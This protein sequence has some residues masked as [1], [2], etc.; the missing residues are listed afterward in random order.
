[1]SLLPW[2]SLSCS[3][4]CSLSWESW[5]VSP[6]LALPIPPNSVVTPV[7]HLHVAIIPRIQV[8]SSHMIQYTLP[9]QKLWSSFPI[10]ST[11][12]LF[13]CCSKSTSSITPTT[14]NKRMASQ[15]L[16]QQCLSSCFICQLMLLPARF[17]VERRYSLHSIH[18]Q[19]KVEYDPFHRMNATVLLYGTWTM[20][21]GVP[22]SLEEGPSKDHRKWCYTQQ[23]HS[24]MVYAELLEL[25]K[26]KELIGFWFRN[27]AYLHSSKWSKQLIIRKFTSH[28]LANWTQRV[29]ILYAV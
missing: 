1:M 14:S 27:T 28:L 29:C 20:P 9:F 6:V 22:L 13:S 23:F 11:R 17:A 4:F 5:F 8:S 19:L 10:C 18:L 7:F 24:L 25:D 21:G 3:H 12:T 15:V 26:R 16:G 2:L